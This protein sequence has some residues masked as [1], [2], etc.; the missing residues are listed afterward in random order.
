MVLVLLLY[1]IRLSIDAAQRTSHGYVVL[2]TSARLVREGAEFSRLYDDGWFGQ[3]TARYDDL[4][5]DIYRPHSPITALILL[6]LSDLDYAKSRVLWIAFNVALFAAASFRMLRELRV[7]GT[8]LLLMI[9]L[10]LLYNPLHVNL[11]LGQSYILMFVLL[12]VAWVGYRRGDH[13]ALGI[14]LGLLLALK[15]A[16]VF[17]WVLLILQRRWSALAWGIGTAALCALIS[18]PIVGIEAWQTYFREVSYFNG[19]PFLTITAYQTPTSLFGHLFTY[20]AQWNPA[21][22]VAAP[23]LASLLT[24][25]SLLGLMGLTSVVAAQRRHHDLVFAAFVMVSVLIVPLALDYHYMLLLLPIMILVAQAGWTRWSKLVL[26]LAVALIATAIA[27]RQPALAAGWW[28]LLAYPKLYG[29]LLLWGLAVWQA[30]RK[31]EAVK[32]GY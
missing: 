6:P 27:Y 23:L 8:H 12:V 13:R 3:Q 11:E 9:A 31:Q 25:G 21:P 10:I 16:G 2:Y 24:W 26:A 4:Y 19:Q 17:L 32:A 1:F 14:A 15:T 30:R 20:D 7:R 5:R 28:A 18:L 29:A 22:L